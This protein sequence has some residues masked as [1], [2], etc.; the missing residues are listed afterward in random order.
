MPYATALLVR[1]GLGE[2]VL[3]INGRDVGRGCDTLLVDFVYKGRAVPLANIVVKGN[4][5]HFPEE[6]LGTGAFPLQWS[7]L[8]A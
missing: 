5:L 8:S 6:K 4:K 7:G 3:A 2:L 1:L